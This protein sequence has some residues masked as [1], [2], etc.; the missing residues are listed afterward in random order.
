MKS[1][2]NR[3]FC[4]EEA[5]KNGHAINR[6]G[7]ATG[8][9]T[10]AD[11]CAPYYMGKFIGFTPEPQGTPLT[12]SPRQAEQSRKTLLNGQLFIER[13]GGLYTVDG[14]QISL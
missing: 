11:V 10:C 12:E 5:T 14:K 1:W 6:T 9:Q 4:N 7:Q 13:N 3:G 8:N 2:L